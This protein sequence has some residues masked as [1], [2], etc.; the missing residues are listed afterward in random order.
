MK[1]YS[2]IGKRLPR[3]D[4]IAKATGSAKYAADLS[5]PGMLH[6]KILRSTLP[7]ARIVSIDT[8]KAMKLTGVRGVITYED[9]GDFKRGL[10]PKTRDEGI[11]AI[12]KV[13]YVGEG[14]AAVAA[15]SE[16]VAQEALELIKVEYEELPAVFDHLEAIKD[17]A[18][19][20]HDHAKNNIAWECHY[21]FGDVEQGF[22]E[23]EYIREDRFSTGHSTHGFLEPHAVLA[24][25]DLGGKLTIWASKQCPYFL[26]RQLALIFNL[27]LSSVRLIQPFVGGG[28]GGKNDGFD[29]D[30]SASLL[31]KKTGKPVKI[32][33]SQRDMLRN[34]RRRHYMVVD[35]KTGVKKDGTLVAMQCTA[36]A[37][38]GAYGGTG[39]VVMYLAGVMLGVPYR[40]PHLKYDGIRIYTNKPT[41]IA[42]RGHGAAHTRYAADVQL[43]MIAKDLGID[44]L[45]I[46]RMNALTAGELT[47]G[48]I[49][50]GTCGFKQSI[51]AVSD[52]VDKNRSE[53]KKD[54]NGNIARGV[55]IAASSF[56]TGERLHPH[57][58]C[59]AVVK[60]NE[61]GTINLLTGASDIGQGS[62]TVLSMIAAEELG[63]TLDDVDFSMIDSA[64]TPIDVGS[65]SSRVT[66]MAGNA[67]KLAAADAKQQLL[68]VASRWLKVPAD[69]IQIK[70]RQVIIKSMPE[71]S[72][73]F[74]QLTKIAS[75]PPESK[76]IVGRGS[77]TFPTVG[78]F[79]FITGE[80]N[81]SEEYSFSTMA[82][83]VKVDTETGQVWHERSV[84]A[85]DCGIALNPMAVEG[86]IEG[87]IVQGQGQTLHEDFIYEKGRTLNTTFADY[88]LPRFMDGP[89]ITAIP[90]ETDCPGGPF[91]AKEAGEGVII[92]TPPALVNAIHDAVG[93]WIKDLPVTP[94]KIL[95]AL[96]AKKKEGN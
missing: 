84:M 68:D 34:G 20:V 47:S 70:N 75:V 43:E 44:P 8:S 78:P 25:F 19:Q 14:V 30:F 81:A 55:G 1:E 22:K 38:G 61:D 83:V 64:F 92:A 56:V 94:E 36:R 87:A 3:I 80:G 41:T 52:V 90:I 4:G 31:S 58:Y 77:Y 29:L 12:N 69:D 71:K 48:K 74:K 28:F 15:V 91:G 72:V 9:F 45:E 63:I 27:P 66:Y 85:H 82:S 89:A 50:V 59:S 24:N 49:K 32:V 73:T 11:F 35:I 21:H 23:S 42:L 86:Q 62:D 5:I 51:E 7:H 40:L 96:R 46:R 16:D 13:R 67:V 79:N 88:K 54:V 39:P 17:G 57:D 93:V 65:Y 53:W 37:D 33:W 2:V 6:G 95:E 76:Q 60:V 26:W 18:P 10:L